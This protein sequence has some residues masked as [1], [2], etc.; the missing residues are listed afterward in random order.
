[1]DLKIE[2]RKLN[3]L[4]EATL[5]FDHAIKERGQTDWRDFTPSRFIYAFFTFNSIYSFDWETSFER[6]EAITWP[7]R[8]LRAYS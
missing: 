2:I 8:R 1:M 3:A 7:Q 4:H 6:N 5:R